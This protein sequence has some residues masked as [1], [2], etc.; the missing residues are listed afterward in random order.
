MKITDAK[1]MRNLVA[2]RAKVQS[3]AEAVVA[4]ILAA[5]QIRGDAA[6]FDYAHKFDGFE[7][8]SLLLTTKDFAA[9]RD[10]LEPELRSALEVA[11]QNIRE[12][13]KLQMPQEFSVEVS[14]GR[15]LGQI[16][17]PLDRIAAYV[18]G[19][20][21][22]LPSTVLMT[23]CT[24]G[25]AGVKDIWMT[26]PK[27]NPVVLGAAAVAG[28]SAGCVL[29][30][31]QAIA[32]FAFG[33]ESIP[34][35]D[36][37]VGPGNA[38]VTAAKKLLAGDVGIDFLAGPTEILIICE[39]GDPVWLAADLLAQAEHDTDASALLLTTSQELAEAVSAEVDRQLQILS[40]GETAKIAIER[41]SAIAVCDSVAECVALSNEIAPE[42]LCIYDP[43]MLSEI[44]SAGSVFVGG[45]STE[46][47][48]DY[49]TGPNHVLPTGGAARL[50]GG[51]S[52]L[53]FVKVISVQELTDEAIRSVGPAG[54]L[55]ARSEGLEGHARSIEARLGELK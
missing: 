11:A 8:D 18:P 43:A 28:A 23:C 49:V 50:S 1:G 19:G 5:V 15:K 12:F 39:D 35:A 52:V 41:N 25:V 22:P 32:A 46:A 40:T 26:S 14:P 9:A 13:A 21:Y 27:P 37:I 7:G 16:V 20:R 2:G 36:R 53:N 44:Q 55:L 38:Y 34:K 30:G 51:L 42:H 10:E 24:A 54:V 45:Y 29:G 47:A 17:R 3:D 4:P 33:T 6:L 48:G 31:A